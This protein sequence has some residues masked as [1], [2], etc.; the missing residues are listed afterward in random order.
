MVAETMP[1]TS[2]AVPLLGIRLTTI[3]QQTTISTKQLNSI[4][5]N[6]HTIQ[7]SRENNQMLICYKW[8][9]EEGK[10]IVEVIK[11]TSI[12]TSSTGE[13]FIDSLHWSFQILLR[14][15]VLDGNNIYFF[16]F[17]FFFLVA[18]DI[19]LFFFGNALSTFPLPSLGVTVLLSLT[20]L[21]NSVTS[22]MPPASAQPLIGKLKQLNRSKQ[23]NK[24]EI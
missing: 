20:F 17:F 10:W 11:K 24:K 1:E 6:T 9:S 4:A 22:S 21:L 5:L 16:F 8:F 23:T 12:S 2:D 18:S 7:I 15:L 3:S 14:H 13:N 19:C